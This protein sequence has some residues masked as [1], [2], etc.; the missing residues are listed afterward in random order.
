[1]CRLMGYVAKEPSHFSELA[2]PA[3][4]DFVQLSSIHC[5]G[6]GIATVDS[7]SSVATLDKAAETACTS[8]QFDTA[9]AA[10]VSDGGLLHLRW[11]TKGLPVSENNA[12][13]FTYRD[14]SF[15]HNGAIF[16]PDAINHE[17][18][19]RYLYL[20]KG[21]TDSESYFY[22][23]LTEIDINGITKGVQRAISVIK[24]K[25]DFSSLNAMLMNEQTLIVVCEHDPLRKP[26]FGDAEYYT[27]KYRESAEGIIIASSGWEQDGWKILPNHHML[28]VDRKTF[29]FEV[30]AV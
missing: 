24:D 17:I 12:H 2:G 14:F 27:L 6:W 25:A 7:G 15:I 19:D 11:A 4:N 26:D 1:M 9:L 10:S 22:L 20:K 3:F 23:L 13:P 18:D 16:P 8:D 28:V 21:D 5:D 29:S 30:L